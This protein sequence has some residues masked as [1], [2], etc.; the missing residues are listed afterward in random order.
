MTFNL[1]LIIMFSYMFYKKG[2]QFLL[3]S[4]IL[5]VSKAETYGY[6]MFLISGTIL[7]NFLGIGVIYHYAPTALIYQVAAGTI[8]SI[9][10]GEAFYIF[11]R[12]M[13]R[14]IPSIQ[15]RKNY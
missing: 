9:C 1:L 12:R 3:Q 5:E 10:I 14:R 6:I 4:K 2:M 15:E 13:F 8:C 7:G 11:N